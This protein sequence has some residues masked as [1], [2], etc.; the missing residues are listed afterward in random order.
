MGAR[1]DSEGERNWFRHIET[2]SVARVLSASTATTTIATAI[3]SRA[4]LTGEPRRG[5]E[6][7]EK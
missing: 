3:S 4:V 6:G 7:E 1:G 5:K 2:K